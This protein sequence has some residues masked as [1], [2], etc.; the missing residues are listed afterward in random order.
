MNYINII[1]MV[2]IGNQLKFSIDLQ[3]PI[4]RQA[5]I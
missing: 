5:A 1:T 3:F 4:F 2:N